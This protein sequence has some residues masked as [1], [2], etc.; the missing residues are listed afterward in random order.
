MA[1]I[2]IN[3]RMDADLKREFEAFCNSVGMS[4]NTAFTIFAKKAVYENRIPFEVSANR[5][6]IETTQAIEETQKMKSGQS[7]GKTYE[8]VDEMMEDILSDV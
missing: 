6:N 2:N 7:T 5:P 8:N 3:I 4:M 1:N